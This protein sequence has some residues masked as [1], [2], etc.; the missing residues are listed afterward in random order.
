M[1]RDLPGIRLPNSFQNFL[2]DRNEDDT[3]SGTFTNDLITINFAQEIKSS[4]SKM[5]QGLFD[6]LA[7]YD[8]S[9]TNNDQSRSSIA[10]DEEYLEQNQHNQGFGMDAFGDGES[11]I[12]QR[13]SSSSSSLLPSR[14]N[15]NIGSVRITSKGLLNKDDVEEVGKT[16]IIFQIFRDVATPKLVNQALHLL[17]LVKIVSK[18]DLG[19]IVLLNINYF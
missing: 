10:N 18:N 1:K 6:L 7:P 15:T 4:T 5:A 2:L 17:L 13:S 19:K 12:I 16:D 9:S 11:G 3:N 8:E 14:T